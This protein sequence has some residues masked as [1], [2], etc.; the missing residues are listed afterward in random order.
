M[1]TRVVIHFVAAE[2]SVPRILGLIERRGFRLR[3]MA[4]SEEEEQA[5]LSVDLEPRNPAKRLDVLGLQLSR[6][7][8]VSDVVL[9]TSA[10][11]E[12]Q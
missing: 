10:P 6:L 1:S 5:L 2:G 12:I 4:M 11:G 9:P 7:H 3:A 8:E